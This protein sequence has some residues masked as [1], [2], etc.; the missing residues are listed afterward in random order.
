MSSSFDNLKMSML[1]RYILMH[2]RSIVYVTRDFSVAAFVERHSDYLIVHL[3]RYLIQLLLV[4]ICV[5]ML[6]CWFLGFCNM[7]HT[8]HNQGKCHNDNAFHSK[9]HC[10]NGHIVVQISVR[11]DCAD[12]IA[13]SLTC[14]WRD[15]THQIGNGCLGKDSKTPGDC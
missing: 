9:C 4:S 14:V 12:A 10:H 11:Y 5:C 13:P 2:A 6:L 1:L 7:F 15:V 3:A 8:D